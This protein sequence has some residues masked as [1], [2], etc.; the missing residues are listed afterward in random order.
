MATEWVCSDGWGWACSSSSGCFD[1]LLV[2]IVSE[3]ETTAQLTLELGRVGAIFQRIP[4]DHSCFASCLFVLAAPGRD[5]GAPTLNRHR[6]ID[7]LPSRMRD[8]PARH[9]VSWSDGF[10][11]L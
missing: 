9:L 7:V 6:S 4:D 2:G 5:S 8:D 11:P 1:V 3:A 10:E